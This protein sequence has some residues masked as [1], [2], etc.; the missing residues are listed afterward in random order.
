MWSTTEM[1][2]ACEVHLEAVSV[3]SGDFS[4]HR[5]ST[6]QRRTLVALDFSC[7]GAHHFEAVRVSVAF[8]AD[9]SL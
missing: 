6:G 8:A 5:R 7:N 2:S 9:T 4:G 3:R 1:Q